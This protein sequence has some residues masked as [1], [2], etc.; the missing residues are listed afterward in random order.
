MERD[1]SLEFVSFLLRFGLTYHC[2]GKR[3]IRRLEFLVIYIIY[4]NY[5][6]VALQVITCTQLISIVSNRKH[7]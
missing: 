6:V 5:D 3:P 4:S 2:F 7:W 1:A